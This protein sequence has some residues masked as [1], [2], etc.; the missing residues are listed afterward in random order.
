MKRT[1]TTMILAPSL[2][3]GLALWSAGLKVEATS[4]LTA[5]PTGS[6]TWTSL[7]NP[8]SPVRNLSNPILLTDGTVIAHVSCTSDWYK[9]TPSN[10]GSYVNGTWSAI[11]ST[12]AGFGPRYFGSAVL[13]DGR[14]VIE[15]GEYNN[16]GD[17]CH[18][19][20]GTQGAIYDPVGNTWTPIPPP[21]GWVSIGDATGI[22]LSDGTYMQT[23]CCDIPPKAALLNPST[24]TW[25]AT[26]T[27][28]FDRYAEESIA[29]LHD[30]TLLTV[31]GY[32]S[33]PTC[34]TGSE[35]YNNVTGAWTFAGS[36]VVQESDCTGVGTF[37]VGPL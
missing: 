26:G 35:R 28:K 27:G 31:D 6:G 8:L 36:T 11:A 1:I 10:T 3:L 23:S 30:D 15:G 22:V 19:A 2:L 7:T 24:L 37:E 9:F 29:L 18:V 25:T 13:P 20:E 5:T 4:A 14:V 21:A 32:V 12:V 34:G 33:K 16:S 17:G